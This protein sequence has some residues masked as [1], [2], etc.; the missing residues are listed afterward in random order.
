MIFSDPVYSTAHK[1]SNILKIENKRQVLHPQT[2]LGTLLCANHSV[3]AAITML[4]HSQKTHK[5]FFWGP[6]STSLTVEC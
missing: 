6:Q 2:I 3:A 5:W 1:H 4:V